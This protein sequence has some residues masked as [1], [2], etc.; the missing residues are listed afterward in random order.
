MKKVMDFIK[1]NTIALACAVVAILGLLA[2]FVYPIPSMFTDL[3]AKVGE[4]SAVFSSLKTLSDE[5]RKLPHVNAS[6]PEP[7]PLETFPTERVIKAGEEA[8]VRLTDQSN[9]ALQAVVKANQRPLLVPNSLPDPPPLARNNFLN[10][11]KA[12]TQQ[13]G[14]AGAK[15]LIATRLKG[16][17]PPTEVEL[18]E[19]EA[20]RTNQI[21][22]NDL[23]TDG[24]GTPINQEEVNQKIA[25][26]RSKL[27]LEQ[28]V[29][30]A[31]KYQIYV[32]P[33]AVDVIQELVNINQPPDAVMVFNGQ[34]S[35]W[36]QSAVFEAIAAANADS[37]NV[38]SSPVK[39]LVRL[40]MPMMYV[41]PP[42]AGG[43]GFFTPGED[44]NAAVPPPDLKPDAT[45]AITPS[46]VGN[47][48]GYTHNSLFDPIP[49]QLTLRVDVRKL[50]EALAAMQG[51]QLLKVKN[52]NYRTVDMGRALQEGYV[53]D[54]NGTTPMV[55]VI[56]DCDVLMLRS[57]LVNYMPEPVKR[58]F[59]NLSNPAVA[60][61]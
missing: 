32:S 10:A 3:N 47:S 22:K 4:R 45:V 44:P 29:T 54:K 15:G 16:T 59:A 33:G 49:V 25:E 58:H 14:E 26:M 13:Y 7:K 35:L 57:W 60:T 48:L 8:I 19:I 5:Q 20:A 24:K 53:Y 6:E 28:R 41:P 2:Y 37:P 51:G 23:Q 1:A 21:M 46:Y 38:L 50:P 17:L 52:V 36:V 55:E 39:H 27:P 34:F 12:I 40:D 43:G 30:R 42:S 31:L 61:E 11:Y 56:L 9:Q 18:A